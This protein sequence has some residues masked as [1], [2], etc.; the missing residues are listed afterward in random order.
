MHRPNNI[1]RHPGKVSFR[2]LA[3]ERNLI[4]DLVW[5]FLLMKKTKWDPASAREAEASRFVRDD[6]L[7]IESGP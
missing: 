6:A 5:L 3:N 4:R 7:L 1:G 2:S